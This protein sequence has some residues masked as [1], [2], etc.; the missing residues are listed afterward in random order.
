M[1]NPLSRPIFCKPAKAIIAA[2]S[3]AK[4][5]IELNI[6]SL[7]TRVASNPFNYQ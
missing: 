4:I 1:L 2:G 7:S 3:A 6:T 5:L